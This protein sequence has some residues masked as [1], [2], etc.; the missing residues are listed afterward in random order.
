M[1]DLL[2]NIPGREPFNRFNW[3]SNK[4]LVLFD[5]DGTCCE[6]R[7]ENEFYI[8]ANG[9]GR[10]WHFEDMYEPGY[11]SNLIPYMNMA[12][13]VSDFSNSKDFEIG[14]LT[15]VLADSPYAADEK[16]EWIR[17]HLPDVPER[18]IIFVPCGTDKGAQI[19]NPNAPVFLID[20]YSNNLR[21]FEAA[22]S[23]GLGRKF[24]IKVYNGINNTHG[25]WKGP[26]VPICGVPPTLIENNLIREVNELTKLYKVEKDGNSRA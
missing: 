6:F 16:I 9:K 24:G 15:A 18:N 21:N 5:M 3:T 12:E 4:P 1:V 8:D 23:L 14:I 17:R 19:N 11:F 22:N 20:D 2:N 26:A 7:C 10:Y 13:V 25:T